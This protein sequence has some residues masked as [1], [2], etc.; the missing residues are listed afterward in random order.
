MDPQ[1]A[2]SAWAATRGDGMEQLPRSSFTRTQLNKTA[3]VRLCEECKEILGRYEPPRTWLNCA[4]SSMTVTGD[5]AG[6]FVFFV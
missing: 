2:T 1:Y 5:V 3:R 4:S 6:F